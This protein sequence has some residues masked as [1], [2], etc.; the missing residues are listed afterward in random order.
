MENNDIIP[1]L[2]R[3]E[4]SKIVAVLSNLFGI[5][6]IEIAEDLA[7]ETFL[8]A[9]ETWPYKGIPKNPSAWLFT[10]AKNKAKNHFIRNSIFRDKITRQMQLKDGQTDEFEIDLSNK[11]IADS[12][13][14]MLFAV[15]HPG[16]SEESQISLALRMLCGFGIDEIA[17]AFLT[18]K[19]T[20]NKRLQRAKQKLRS[21]NV[22]IEIPRNDQLKTRLDAVLR[23]IYLLF[24][25]GYYSESHNSII[26]KELCLE[27]MNLTYLLLKNNLTNTHSTNS[28]MSLMCFHS[29]RLEARLTEKGE[30]ILYHDQDENLWDSE[31]IEKGFYYLQQA[32]KLEI[33]SKYYLEASIAY[34]HTVK[35]DTKEKW[36]SI[37]NLYDLLLK[38]DYTPI[39]DLNRIFALSKVKGNELA[40][41]EAEKL[42]LKNNHFYYL[43]LSELYKVTDRNKAKG[44]MEKA[45]KLCKTETEKIFI[46]K[47]IKKFEGE[48]RK[49]TA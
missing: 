2:F 32:S 19:E 29:S 3:S 10:V 23:T 11:N 26:K 43:L 38:I 7:S 14:Q 1:H 6:H 13:L 16:I 20:I 36:K 9:M 30:I 35:K 42:K 21:E 33:G 31:L 34:W 25:E 8:T 4:Y 39:A 37:L 15:C 5:E 49:P 45:L 40:I 27:A 44:S 24:N 48:W 12:Q 47:N 46:R 28:L 22:Q 41:I 17:I 18:N